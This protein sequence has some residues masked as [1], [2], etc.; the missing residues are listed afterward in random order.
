MQQGQCY[1][2]AQSA[3]AARNESNFFGEFA[4]HVTPPRNLNKAYL[5]AVLHL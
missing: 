3:G 2:P 4:N 1:G 5:K